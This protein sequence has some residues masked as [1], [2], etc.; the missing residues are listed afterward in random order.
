MLHGKCAACDENSWGL[1]VRVCE[2]VMMSGE[3]MGDPFCDMNHQNRIKEE[4]KRFGGYTRCVCSFLDK[5]FKRVRS[6]MSDQ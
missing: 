1:D 6:F 2:R 4:R 5:E 3:R